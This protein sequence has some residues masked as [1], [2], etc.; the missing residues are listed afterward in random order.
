[1][2]AID[3]LSLLALPNC[4]DTIGSPDVSA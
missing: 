2:C 3:M 1:V 4:V